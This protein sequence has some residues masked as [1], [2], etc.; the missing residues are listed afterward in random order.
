MERDII[1]M[2]QDQGMGIAPWGTL[3]QGNLKT[4]QQ[5]EDKKNN[6]EGRNAPGR[7][8]TE[9]D[10]KTSA[11]LEKIAEKHD[12]QLTSVV[13]ILSSIPNHPPQHTNEIPPRHSP[14]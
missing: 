12:T 14:T 11:V 4:A 10:L 3:G 5:F 2:C 1:P 6:P 13:R 8:P 7:G 9:N